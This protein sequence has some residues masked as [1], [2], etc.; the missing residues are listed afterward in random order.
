MRQTSLVPMPNIRNPSSWTQICGTKD[1]SYSNTARPALTHHP[2]AL[3]AVVV[4]YYN[5]TT[6]TTR[7]R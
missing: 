4:G 7:C 5:A 3:L 6:K 1:I 2:Q